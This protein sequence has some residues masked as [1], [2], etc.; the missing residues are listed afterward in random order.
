MCALCLAGDVQVHHRWVW[1]EIN[2]AG[3]ASRI[4]GL[5][6][7]GGGI[8]TRDARAPWQESL[9]RDPQQDFDKL[10]QEEAAGRSVSIQGSSHR[11]SPL[12]DVDSDLFEP[13]MRTQLQHTVGA[14]HFGA[15][16]KVDANLVDG[17]PSSGHPFATGSPERSDHAKQ[18][19]ERAG[20]KGSPP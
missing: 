8:G 9:R 19:E 20:E 15:A 14:A 10:I 13:G 12:A 3:A 1:S 6:V 4:K 16:D 18:S 2:P 5:P 17:A 11:R 7:Y